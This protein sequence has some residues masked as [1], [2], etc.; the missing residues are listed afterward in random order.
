MATRMSV[1]SVLAASA[2]GSQTDVERGRLW[3]LFDIADIA[4]AAEGKGSFVRGE[5]FP[6][7]LATTAFIESTDNVDMPFKLHG[8]HGFMEGA[9]VNYVSTEI[10]Q[11]FDHVWAQPMY[12][13]IDADGKP[14]DDAAVAE[15]WVFGV[16]PKSA[17]YSPFWEEYGFV[18][19]DGVDVTTVLDARTVLTLANAT[20]GLRRL[21]RRITS[22]EPAT[23]GRFAESPET[24]YFDDT[25]AWY[26]EGGRRYLDFGPG[27]F[28][29]DAGGVVAE[30]PLF[31]FV[32]REDGDVVPIDGFP[33]VLGTRAPF[34]ATPSTLPA[35]GATMIAE[36]I[37]FGGLWRMYQ[38]ELPRNSLTLMADGQISY[39]GS[40]GTFVLNSQG[41]VE[42]VG[43]SYIHRTNLLISCPV[44]R[45]GDREFD[46]PSPPKPM[47]VQ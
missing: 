5:D 32:T 8:G 7:G 23:V 1:A 27:R 33:T 31:K 22:I 13:A 29:T 18:L 30:Y 38:V 21:G 40:A 44:L 16:G 2:C 45:V 25:A 15:P 17:F 11:N 9:V 43:P 14:L 28:D 3:T 26:G 36:D 24:N 6:H 47:P 37:P 19:P 39:A 46:P 4:T 41:A 12:R 42:S 35:G 10:W 34:S 20:G